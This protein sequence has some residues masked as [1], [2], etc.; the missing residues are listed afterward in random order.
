MYG[1]PQ[2]ER[3]PDER[4]DLYKTRPGRSPTSNLKYQANCAVPEGNHTIPLLRNLTP[5][6]RSHSHTRT[7][8]W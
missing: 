2:G 4:Q 1:Q 3:L 8:L 6:C 7:I 5:M